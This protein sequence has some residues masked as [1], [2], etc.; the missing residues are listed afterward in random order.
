MRRSLARPSKTLNIFFTCF[1]NLKIFDA[2][3]RGRKLYPLNTTRYG[4]RL[5]HHIR[6]HDLCPG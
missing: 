4:F 2:Q 1:E 6:I 5:N 3:K